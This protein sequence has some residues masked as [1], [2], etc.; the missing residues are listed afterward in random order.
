MK[1]KIIQFCL[2]RVISDKKIIFVHVPKCG[3]TS[4]DLLI[5]RRFPMQRFRLNAR[6]SLKASELIGEDLNLVRNT[7]LNYAVCTGYKFISGH[8]YMHH[9]EQY[10]AYK[11]ITVLRDP[12]KRFLSHYLYNR[13]KTH[14]THYAIDLEFEDFIDT[15]LAVSCGN[16]YCRYFSKNLD[17]DESIATLEKFSS[18]GILENL[19]PFKNYVTQELKINGKLKR[20]NKSPLKDSSQQEEILSKY[21]DRILRLCDDDIKIYEHFASRVTA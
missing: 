12:V 18:V 11:T 6:A 1:N 17:P 2:S 5:K 3:G 19:G 10:E 20:K 15:D 9:P 7:L 16:L 13:Y 21:R 8:F 4:L 14:T